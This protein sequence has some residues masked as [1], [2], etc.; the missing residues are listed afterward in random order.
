MS[1]PT[2]Q[3]V[4]CAMGIVPI[5]DNKLFVGKATGGTA[6]VRAQAVMGLIPASA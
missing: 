4:V 1:L 3:D 2:G 6:E 5:P